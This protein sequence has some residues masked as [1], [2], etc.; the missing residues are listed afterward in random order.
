[1]V[2]D[3]VAVYVGCGFADA[4]VDDAFRSWFPTSAGPPDPPVPGN[5]QGRSPCSASHHLQLLTHS[6]PP[7]LHNFFVVVAALELDSSAAV[8]GTAML[9]MESETAALEGRDLAVAVV[10]VDLGGT[11]CDNDTRT[12][13]NTPVRFMMNGVRLQ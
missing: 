6:D 2:E 4:D 1:L 8:R 11:K 7:V 12:A 3:Y 10:V 5:H 9:Y 13:L